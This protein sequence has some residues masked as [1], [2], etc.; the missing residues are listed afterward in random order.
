MLRAGVKVGAVRPVADRAGALQDRWC[1]SSLRDRRSRRSEGRASSAALRSAVPSACAWRRP[2]PR[3]RRRACGEVPGHARVRTASQLPRG[4]RLLCPASCELLDRV[5]AR[6]A[7][8]R[9]ALRAVG[10]HRVGHEEVGARATQALLGLARPRRGRAGAV[11]LRPPG[12]GPPRPITVRRM[13][14]RPPVHYRRASA[15]AD[16]ARP[17][18]LPSSASTCHPCAANLCGTSSEK[19]ERGRPVDRDLV[20]VVELDHIVELPM[21]RR[22]SP[23]RR[24]PP[25]SGRRR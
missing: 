13:S 2:C 18:S 9:R 15:S 6:R 3:G 21:A 17:T 8:R 11:R 16:P 10:A 20:V 1:R 14:E 4:G 5:R 7:L 24:R 23:P 12:H 22:A 25:P 19:D